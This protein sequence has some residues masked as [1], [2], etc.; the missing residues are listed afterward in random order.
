MTYVPNMIYIC[1]NTIFVFFF[2][3]KQLIQPN[4]SNIRIKKKKKKKQQHE[5]R[6][7][8]WDIFPTPKE[9]QNTKNKSYSLILKGKKSMKT[10][11]E[12]IH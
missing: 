4:M 11:I 1:P 10:S 12:L 2:L 8:F 6:A 3:E 9:L 7:P 5:L